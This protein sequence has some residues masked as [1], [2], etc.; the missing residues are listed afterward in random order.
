MSDELKSCPFCGSGASETFNGTVRGVRCDD[1]AAD[2]SWYADS[3]SARTAWN[4]RAADADPN[5]A[6]I[7]R[8]VAECDLIL[9]AGRYS[10]NYRDAAIKIKNILEGGE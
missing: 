4:K 1:C 2:I 10:V 8:A 5:A 9:K 6:I 3:E 7:E